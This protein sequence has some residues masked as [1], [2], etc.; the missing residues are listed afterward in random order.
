MENQAES[1][2]NPGGLAG[3][4]AENTPEHMCPGLLQAE[5]Q[6]VSSDTNLKTILA[7]KPDGPQFNITLGAE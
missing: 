2:D 7:P 6:T 4:W 3:K 1:V 5:F